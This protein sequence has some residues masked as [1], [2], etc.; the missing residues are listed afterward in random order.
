MFKLCFVACSFFVLWFYLLCSYTKYF[1][2]RCREEIEEVIGGRQ[3]SMSDLYS[4]PYLQATIAEVFS[5]LFL[6]MFSASLLLN[7]NDFLAWQQQMFKSFL[8]SE[9]KDIMLFPHLTHLCFPH[10]A[11]NF[12]EMQKSLSVRFWK[13]FGI[14][15]VQRMSCVGPL[16]LPHVTTSAASIGRLAMIKS[17]IESFHT[18]LST[19]TLLLKVLFSCKVNVLCQPKLLL[20]QPRHF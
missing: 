10:V 18:F 12:A 17:T 11:S 16:S 8:F 14:F 3:A 7:L 1:L 4:L 6:L 15:Q 5:N 19:H 2:C 9:A 13:C 20:K